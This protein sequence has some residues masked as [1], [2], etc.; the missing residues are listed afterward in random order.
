MGG[1][2][3][4]SI[5]AARAFGHHKGELCLSGLKDIP[6]DVAA[7]LANHEEVIYYEDPIDVT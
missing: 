7:E 6:T 4:L 3:K 2:T 5:E 1:L